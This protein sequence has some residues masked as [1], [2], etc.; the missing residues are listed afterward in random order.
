MLGFLQ[1]PSSDPIDLLITLGHIQGY[2][3]GGHRAPTDV[4][5]D[6]DHIA[7]NP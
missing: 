6:K 5:P 1:Y 7:E 4:R 3:Q 2:T